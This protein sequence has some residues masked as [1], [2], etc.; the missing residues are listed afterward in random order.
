MILKCQDISV[1]YGKKIRALKTVSMNIKRGEIVAF[2][3]ANGA[4]KST[5][6]RT[7]SGLL[8]A[9]SGEIFF[10][11]Q[12]IHFLPCH[13]IAALGIAHVPEGR[14]IFSGLTVMENLELGAFHQAKQIP[15]NLEKVYALFPVLK[16]R[17][18]QLGGTLSGGEQQM[19]AIARALMSNPKLLMLDEPSM[20]L[21]PILVEKIFETIKQIS[22]QGNTIL[23]VEQNAHQSL[24]LA[25]RAYVLETGK[26]VMEGDG[27]TLLKNETIQ[28]AYLGTV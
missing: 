28:H 14:H 9:E 24:A 18:S 21:A 6:L 2:I 17:S 25:H 4:G 12:P 19:L 27:A 1:V 13:R 10:E 8:R 16:E 15:E 26:V 7:V 22:L 11:D 5:F 23:L 3:G 20:G